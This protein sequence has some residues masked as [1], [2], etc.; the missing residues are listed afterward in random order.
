MVSA[1][2]GTLSAAQAVGGCRQAPAPAPKVVAADPGALER[3]RTAMDGR[4]YGSAVLLLREALAQDPADREAHYRLAVSASHLDQTEE[5][6]REFEWVVA[7]GAAGAPE[8]QI[9]RDWLASRT[10]QSA[11]APRAPSAAAANPGMASLVGRAVGPEGAKP[12]FPL[13]L[14][15]L[16]GTA[17]ADEYHVIRTDQH[18]SFQFADVVPG[19]YMLTAAIAGPPMWRLRVSVAKGQRLVLDLSPANLATIRDDF[20]GLRP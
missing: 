11:P 1:L 7:S 6:G 17:V 14:K 4:D 19:D 2:I 18:G 10:R 20:P 9:A 3:A 12:R 8:V 13:Y 5:A 15:G 16:P